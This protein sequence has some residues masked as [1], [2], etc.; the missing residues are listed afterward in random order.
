MERRAIDKRSPT[1]QIRKR[2]EKIDE[3]FREGD[4]DNSGDLSHAEIEAYRRLKKQSS[5][6]QRMQRMEKK[7]DTLTRT[8]EKFLGEMSVEKKDV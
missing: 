1:H 2:L 5:M 3:V 8:M 7:L 4:L 6:A